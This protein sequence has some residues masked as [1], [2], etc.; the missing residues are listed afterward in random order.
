M[1][2]RDL[3]FRVIAFSRDSVT[4]FSGPVCERVERGSQPRVWLA[5]EQVPVRAGGFSLREG[6][7]LTIERGI[8]TGEGG[9][10]RQRRLMETEK[11]RISGYRVSLRLLELGYQ[12]GN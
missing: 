6:M 3:R 10:A 4:F 12:A 5:S 7:V 2:T 9:E 11:W 1:L 8:Y